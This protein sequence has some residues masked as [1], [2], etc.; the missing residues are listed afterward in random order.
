MKIVSLVSLTIFLGVVVYQMLKSGDESVEQYRNRQTKFNNRYQDFEKNKKKLALGEDNLNKRKYEHAA[1]V[2]DVNEECQKDIE[3]K[4]EE[5]LIDVEYDKYKNADRIIA[6]YKEIAAYILKVRKG[7]QKDIDK[8]LDN[9]VYEDLTYL[10]ETCHPQRWGMFV[11]TLIDAS[12]HHKW[13]SSERLKLLS[14]MLRF[15]RANLEFE[16]NIQHAWRI[17]FLID[18][19]EKEKLLEGTKELHLLVKKFMS[20]YQVFQD[21][22]AEGSPGNQTLDRKIIIEEYEARR[23]WHIEIKNELDK[24]IILNDL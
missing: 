17:Q 11:D 6:L 23:D 15:F 21:T 12:I 18:K 8:S 9:L 7:T 5:D 10:K 4:L 20:S 24:V 22:Y 2:Y 14:A 19:I 16:F 3:S 1:I 13:K